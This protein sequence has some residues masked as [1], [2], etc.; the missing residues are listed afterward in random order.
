MSIV[1]GGV[2]DT[3][4]RTGKILQKVLITITTI[5]AQPTDCLIF[6]VQP[7]ICYLF[8]VQPRVL[9]D[10]QSAAR[11]VARY[12]QCTQ[13]FA[14]YLEGRP[15]LLDIQSAATFYPHINSLL[16]IYSVDKTLLHIYNIL[17]RICDISKMQ[18]RFCLIITVQIWLH[19]YNCMGQSLLDIQSV[20]PA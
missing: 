11:S 3:F 17:K 6:T 8:T 12:F 1:Q 5:L 15:K 7:R 14:G 10:I 18:P 9:L 13:E 2:G 4:H 19:N 16:R 20:A